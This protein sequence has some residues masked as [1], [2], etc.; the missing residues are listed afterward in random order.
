MN[1]GTNIAAAL[2]AAGKLLKKGEAAG[3]T[4]KAVVLITD[5]RI[6]S[7]QVGAGEE[8]KYIGRDAWHGAKEAGHIMLC[9]QLQH[10]IQASK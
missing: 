9:E 4:A 2:L 1:G 8:R 7:Y 10:G 3:A 6:D 5:G